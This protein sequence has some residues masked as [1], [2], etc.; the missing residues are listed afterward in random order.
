[1]N[2]AGSVTY[3]T[4]F[5][6]AWSGGTTPASTFDSQA[7]A[8]NASDDEVSTGSATIAE[9]NSLAISVVVADVAGTTPT[10]TCAGFSLSNFYDSTPGPT[11]VGGAGLAWKENVSGSISAD[12]TVA[13]ATDIAAALA[14]FKPAASPG[15]FLSR[16][17]LLGAG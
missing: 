8:G 2:G 3:P 15:G 14:I 11:A 10:A 5:V 16:L 6:Q 17:S 1:V 9:A 7:G 4:I 12:W 13:S